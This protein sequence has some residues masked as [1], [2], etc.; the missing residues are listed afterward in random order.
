M[1]YSLI[2]SQNANVKQKIKKIENKK[3]KTSHTLKTAHVSMLNKISKKQSFCLI[4]MRFHHS[5]IVTYIFT[6]FVSSI[7]SSSSDFQMMKIEEKKIDEFS[8]I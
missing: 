3:R 2:Y 7:L 1:M 8:F 6:N 4:Q 5:L